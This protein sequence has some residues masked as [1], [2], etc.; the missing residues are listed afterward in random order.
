[1]FDAIAVEDACLSRAVENESLVYPN[2][3]RI[4]LFYT[5][6]YMHVS[7]TLSGARASNEY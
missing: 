5:A 3:E 4:I 7:T 1:M 6:N 2:S